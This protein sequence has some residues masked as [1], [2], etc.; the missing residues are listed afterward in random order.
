LYWKDSINVLQDLDQFDKLYI[1]YHGC[2]WTKYGTHYGNGQNYDEQGQNQDQNDQDSYGNGCGG[3]GGEHFWYLGRTQCFK[4]NVAYSLY[5]I[6]KGRDDVGCG[7]ATY[8][9]S[10]FTTFGAESFTGPLGLGSDSG[11]SY[12]TAIQGNE[13]GNQDNRNNDDDMWSFYAADDDYVDDNY[14][15]VDFSSYTSTG[16]GCTADGSFTQDLYKG[17]FCHGSHYL[18]TVDALSNFN[19]LL[20]QQSC[21]QIYSSG[22]DQDYEQPDYD[23]DQ[24]YDFDN[25][26][27]VH[28]LSFSKSC[29]LRQ[30]PKVRAP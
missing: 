5:G 19:G 25:M 9:N 15:F 10:F 8:I 3:W 7:K 14:Q 20:Q 29:S 24:G 26:N 30:Y 21:T 2:V 1:E 11:N 17:A 12:C 6:L 27:A 22:N 13:N 28:L 16:T 23:D 18:E 4:A